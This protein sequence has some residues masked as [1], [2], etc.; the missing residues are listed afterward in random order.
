LAWM[1]AGCREWQVDGLRE[2]EVVRKATAEYRKDSNVVGRFIDECCSEREM[3]CT[4]S[5]ALYKAFAEWN[6]GRPSLSRIDFGV[7]LAERGLQDARMTCGPDKGKKCWQGIGLFAKG[8][9]DE[10]DQTSEAVKQGEV[11]ETEK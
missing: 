11:A 2:P 5:E 3:Y 8:S 9:Q 4:T 6:G 7:A 10:E 1:V